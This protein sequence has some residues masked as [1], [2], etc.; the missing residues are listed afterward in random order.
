MT[1]LDYLKTVITDDCV[2]LSLKTFSQSLSVHSPLC[3]AAGILP[4]QSLVSV[5][6]LYNVVIL[7]DFLIS[8]YLAVGI[9]VYVQ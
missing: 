4:W 1:V 6:Q 7:T 3:F 5:A 8:I 9:H 2:R